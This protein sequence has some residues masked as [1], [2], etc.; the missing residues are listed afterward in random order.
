MLKVFF[1]RFDKNVAK[2]GRRRS[3]KGRFFSFFL[4][5]PFLSF[6]FHLDPEII[7]WQNLKLDLAA[8]PSSI[9]QKAECKDPSHCVKGQWAKKENGEKRP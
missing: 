2:L 6:F 8:E 7:L 9:S 1:A 4:K 5:Q 3:R